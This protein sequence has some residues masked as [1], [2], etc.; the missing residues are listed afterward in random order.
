[1]A[2][3][4]DRQT[5]SRNMAAIRGA[6]TKPELFIRRGLHARGFRFR[7]HNRKLP[8]RPDLVLP[9][10][11]AVILINGCFWHGHECPLFKWP[12]TREEFWRNKIGGNV[13]RDKR[14]QAAL[15]VSGWRVG[16]VWE[17]ALKGKRRLQPAYVLDRLREWLEG[18][19]AD[20]M[21]EG[22][23]QETTDTLA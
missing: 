4:H 22:Q 1:M 8:G 19:A 13:E 18:D 3:V 7:L 6:D 16:I 17:C 12:K 21:I 11:Q 14:N 10:Y 5:R 20:C 15:K 9:R 2:D 23:D